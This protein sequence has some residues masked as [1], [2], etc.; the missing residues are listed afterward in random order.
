MIDRLTRENDRLQI[1]LE[2]AEKAY[3]SLL[4][5]YTELKEQKEIMEKAFKEVRDLL[6]Y[7]INHNYA[8]KD[9]KEEKGSCTI[10]EQDFQEGQRYRPDRWYTRPPRD[11]TSD[12]Y[13][14]TLCSTTREHGLMELLE[15]NDSDYESAMRDDQDDGWEDE[16][17]RTR[18]F[19]KACN[20]RW[21]CKRTRSCKR[22]KWGQCS[23]L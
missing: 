4:Y 9:S 13:T 1:K 19:I 5:D 10:T 22:N 16:E 18:K 12:W 17:T 7:L 15:S 14:I 3:M 8:S 2:A 21:D 6:D 20:R 11:I 23:K